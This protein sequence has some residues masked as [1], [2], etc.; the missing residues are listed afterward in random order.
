MEHDTKNNFNFTT[1]LDIILFN[2]NFSHS[3]QHKN[4]TNQLHELNEIYYFY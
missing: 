2:F 4:Y 1:K 3:T